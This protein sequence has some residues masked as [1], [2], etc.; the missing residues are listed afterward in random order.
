[1][2]FED[3]VVQCART[4]KPTTTTVK[5]TT[6]SPNVTTAVPVNPDG[7]KGGFDGWSFF[8]GIVLALVGVAI[9]FLSVKYWKIRRGQTTGGD[10]NRF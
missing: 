5:S 7:G 4:L 8:G 6:I 2:K 9:S 1:M 3:Y 10:Y